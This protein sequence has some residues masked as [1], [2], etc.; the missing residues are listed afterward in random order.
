MRVHARAGLPREVVAIAWM[1]FALSLVV[2]EA[3][4]FVV[5]SP[6]DSIYSDM[7]GYVERAREMVDG[8][9]RV[10]PRLRAFYP[11]GTHYAFALL[12]RL[13]GEQ[14]TAAVRVVYAAMAAFPAYHFVLL[15]SRLFR[16][17]WVLA[18]LGG[19]FALWQ[20]LVWT[21]GFFVSE[22]PFTCLLF[23]N[24]WLM[25]EFASARRGGLRLGLTSAVLFAVRPQFVLTFGL[26]ALVFALERGPLLVRRY[27]L[28]AYARV[29]APCLLVLAFSTVR[30]HELS[31]RWGLISENS[32][33]N[34]LLADT[35]YA[36]VDARWTTPAGGR[37][38]FWIEAP[39]KVAV[40]EHGGINIEGYV[41]DVALLDAERRR[42]LA[43]KS[44]GWRVRRALRNVQLL[45]R[46][47]DPWPEDELVNPWP[48]HALQEGF[49]AVVRTLVLPLAVV[50]AFAARRR[51][52]LA[53][54]LA[55]VATAIVL[56]ML[57]FPEARYR[58]PYDPML[59]ILAFAGF[60]A[61][62]NRLAAALGLEP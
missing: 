38:T 41:G 60:G 6:F 26:L 3:W 27:A 57:Y 12:F 42:F 35:T 8:V 49:N 2:R 58:V 43:D 32:G 54:I 51:A 31:G 5:Q 39:A 50:G 62:L 36:R 20:P 7:S 61:L 25:V 11:Y 23:Y 13:V 4:I 34:R 19:L 21:V 46:W 24:A 55:H 44:L 18:A 47:N 53:V 30:L 16:S 45:Y 48:R 10:Y 56:A 9:P 37:Y 22:V 28:G 40:G 59:L 52:A 17:V 14:H 1:A 15:A 33:L 29:L